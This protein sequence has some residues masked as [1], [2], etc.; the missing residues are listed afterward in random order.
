MADPSRRPPAVSVLL[1]PQAGREFLL[2]R[3]ESTLGSDPGCD[4]SVAA[5]GVAPVHARLRL[6]ID[7]A[8]LVPEPG[9]EGL[10]RNDDPVTGESALASGDV[11]WLGAPGEPG[12]VM[13]QC[14]LPADLAAFVAE[15]GAPVAVEPVLHEEPEPI[16]EA[17]EPESALEPEPEL[18]V[19]PHAEVEEA[20]PESV[21]PHA[22][23]VVD[24]GEATIALS[25]PP[26]L[27]PPVPAAEEVV[28][29]AAT[30][31]DVPLPDLAPAESFEATL[32]DMAPVAEEI[33]EE[34]PE[35]FE[36]EA[37]PPA[38]VVVDEDL[39]PDPQATMVLPRPEAPDDAEYAPT[40]SLK[41][42]PGPAQPEPAAVA[43]PPEPVPAPP[44]APPQAPPTRPEKSAP[45]PAPSAARP[46]AAPA[47][48]PRPATATPPAAPRPAAAA[49]RRPAPPTARPA[50]APAAAPVPPSAASG[51]KVG[52]FVGAGLVVAVAVGGFLWMNQAPAPPATAPAAPPTAPPTTMAALPPPTTA[53]A[54]PEP[55]VA[56]ES[57][58]PAPTPA[59]TAPPAAAAKPPTAA[60]KPAAR[61]AATPPP[62]AAKA[63]AAKAPPAKA[64][65]PTGPDPAEV[66]AQQLAG[67][68]DRGQTALQARQ[69]DAASAAFKEA[70]ALEP[71][72]ARATS[73]ASAA[74]AG[75][76]EARRRFVPGRSFFLA[77]PS[78]KAP[79][80][81]NTQDVTVANPDYSA[82]VQFEATPQSVHAG[83]AWKV[84]VYALNDGKKAIKLETLNAFVT[85]NGSRAAVPAALK[86]RE[87][88]P[89]QRALLAEVTGDWRDGVKSWSLDVVATT[90]REETL[91]GSLGW[92]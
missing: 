1:G 40:V 54:A 57:A 51:S 92:K 63:A 56:E 16:L 48:R 89:N 27:L 18:I 10:F 71:G 30:V 60:A 83:V 55:T 22:E 36:V 23:P 4:V 32:V 82:Q 78:G 81:F 2:Q 88:A 24:E 70:L 11:V 91:K 37:P 5:P 59:P 17:A 15:L 47:A 44:A 12:S 84:Q 53:P 76:A 61:V 38:P 77:K 62:A 46:P 28:D 67:L 3:P 19:E 21:E 34:V 69:F 13:L 72:N 87:L 68:L 29:F 39:G 33:V 90:T 26:P 66:R 25:S 45:K 20:P 73:G 50:P 9:A 43:P 65:A 35:R 85:V 42:Q 31:A 6:T 41:R 7:G 79:A 49:P 74:E 52:L 80:G 75:A 8:R 64:P 14:R 86:A 58:E